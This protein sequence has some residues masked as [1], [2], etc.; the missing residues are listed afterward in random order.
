MSIEESVGD[1]REQKYEVMTS[2]SVFGVH[3]RR[4]FANLVGLL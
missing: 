2:V 1:N 4:T 3:R